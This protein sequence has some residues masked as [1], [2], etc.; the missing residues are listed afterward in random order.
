MILIIHSSHY[1]WVPG[2]PNSDPY[3]ACMQACQRLLAHFPRSFTLTLL[4]Q[5]VG[6]GRA[7]KAREVIFGFD[8]GVIKGYIGIMKIEWKLQGL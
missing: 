2:P 1:F 3:A 4:H 6:W 5:I 8:I 7:V